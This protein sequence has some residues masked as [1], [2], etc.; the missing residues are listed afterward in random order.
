MDAA[1]FYVKYLL[2]MILIMSAPILTNAQTTESVIPSTDCAAIVMASKEQEIVLETL[3]KYANMA[4]SPV[5]IQ[6]SNGYFAAALGIFNKKEGL[7]FVKENIS[8]NRI[9]KDSVCLNAKR[10]IGILYPNESFTALSTEKTVKTVN[11]EQLSQLSLD[12]I[13]KTQTQIQVDNSSKPT[14]T[15]QKN[16][17]TDDIEETL[18]EEALL[19]EI[20]NKEM[21]K[22]KIANIERL[23][24]SRKEEALLQ[25]AAY[26]EMEK[27]KSANNKSLTESRK[28]EALLQA[29]ANKEI[30]KPNTTNIKMLKESIKEEA[31]SN[32]LPSDVSKSE[33]TEKY[34]SNTEECIFE[35]GPYHVRPG[36]VDDNLKKHINLLSSLSDSNLRYKIFL[37]ENP[38]SG[39]DK[40]MIYSLV[41]VDDNTDYSVIGRISTKLQNLGL[42]SSTNCV[43]VQRGQ[44]ETL[45]QSA[46]MEKLNIIINESQTCYV[47]LD[48]DKYSNRISMRSYKYKNWKD[49]KNALEELDKNLI[50]E[51]KEINSKLSQTLSFDQLLYILM[52]DTHDQMYRYAVFKGSRFDIDK[53]LI[54]ASKALSEIHY[55]IDKACNS[56]IE[57]NKVLA[58]KGLLDREKRRGIWLTSAEEIEKNNNKALVKL[59]QLIALEDGANSKKEAD[60]KN[61]KASVPP[62]P[63]N[64]SNNKVVKESYGFMLGADN[65][66]DVTNGYRIDNCKVEF[67]VDTG[68]FRLDITHD[69]NLVKWKSA[70]YKLVDLKPNFYVAC[71]GNCL[72]QRAY[73][74]N[75]E[76]VGLAKMSDGAKQNFI[77]FP[78]TVTKD[79]FE[80]ALKDVAKECPGSSSKY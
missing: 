55:V 12:P 33:T 18:K 49:E 66:W 29:A 74:E 42:N 60:R 65:G 63:D 68:L 36:Y 27:L 30:E 23:K 22:L 15:K 8:A 3:K 45:E 20:A 70:S 4:P 56:E 69:L 78:I 61:L 11:T 25:A 77:Q 79:R 73:A 44:F 2:S 50:G 48:T 67:S 76:F 75:P 6:S 9:P 57:F 5:L 72:S 34:K 31:S 43:N 46:F 47:A 32:E 39:D 51:Y 16:I 7:A 71:D 17:G 62:L 24:E 53:G 21:E 14:I 58:R 26:K 80:K 1:K 52:P 40:V 35:I 13:L 59:N 19:Q 10:F 41:K 54:Q 37:K 64:R 38:F 28:E